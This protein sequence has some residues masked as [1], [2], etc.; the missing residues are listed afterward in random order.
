MNPEGQ[1][2]H[3]EFATALLYELPI[4]VS[5]LLEVVLAN[6]P[7]P[8]SSIVIIMLVVV[9][10][11]VEIVIRIVVVVRIIIIIVVVVV[12]ISNSNRN[13]EVINDIASMYNNK[14]LI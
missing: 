10:V 7:G 4:Q 3:S 13:N 9:I 5:H 14:L 8:N 6:V 12:Y 2:K 11:V 1:V